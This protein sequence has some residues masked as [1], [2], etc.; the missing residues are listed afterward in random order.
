MQENVQ[1]LREG[2]DP[3]AL[4]KKLGEST[5]ISANATKLQKEKE[6]FEVLIIEINSVVI[7]LISLFLTLESGTYKEQQRF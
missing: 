6:S 1:P 3:K 7:V 2:R 4:A 5:A